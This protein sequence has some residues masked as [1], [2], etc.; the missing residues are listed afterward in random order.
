MDVTGNSCGCSFVDTSFLPQICGSG[1]LMFMG[2]VE[3]L[4]KDQCSISDP[5]RREGLD[6]I[7]TY[8]HYDFIVVG[9]GVAGPVVAS[10]LS[11]ISSWNVLLIEAGPHEPTITSVPAFAMTARG[12]VLDWNYQTENTTLACL[13][14]GGRC[15]WSR[16]KMVAG[17]SGMQ[18]MMY[19]RPHPAILDIW[20]ENVTG[21][22]FSDVLPY[23]IK[24]ENNLNPEMVE[25]GYHGFSGPMTV[26]QFPSRPEMA[27]AVV[28][29]GIELGYR[30]GDLNGQNQTGGAVA[31][32]MVFEGLRMSTS[33][34]Y[35]R[36]F[37]KE[38]DNL[39][40]LVNAQVTKVLIH[41]DTKKAYGVEYVDTNG[42]T[43]TIYAEKEVILSAGAVNSPQLLL[44]SGIGPKEDLTSVG[45][46]PIVDLPGVGQNLQN[47]VAGSVSFH[48]NDDSRN[49]L[50]L[51]AVNEFINSR[52]GNLSSTG[53][54]QTTLFMKS[55]Y[56]TDDVPD[57]Q[58]FFDGY[59][60][61]CSMTG[62]DGECTGTGLVGSCAQR[63]IYA[64]PT[65]VRPLSRGYLTLKSS[66]PLDP[67]LIYPNYLQELQ[68][69]DVLVDGL[70]L[71]LQMANT[72]AMQKYNLE[73][74][75]N[76]VSG[77]ENYT[78]ASDEYFACSV[79]MA[80]G[81]ENHQAGTC[82]MGAATDQTSVVDNELK[83]HGVSNIRVID[84]SIFPV[85]P[86]SNPTSVII[87]AA[88]KISDV[89]KAS[90]EESAPSRTV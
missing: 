26:Q 44:L 9:A 72:T 87:M 76:P 48:I 21:W 27:N 39:K 85:N 71:C 60:S 30:N 28:E 46:E 20:N 45:I 41:N 34:A 66:N 68:D 47:H 74:N 55:K 3:H 80:T 49:T 11:E 36:P 83:V 69:V 54:T 58:V 1:F 6:Y 18:G 2:L 90:W 29:A 67:P 75:V 4:L 31:Q 43:H 40:L 82:K 37:Y 32:M 57:L 50:T 89:I 51:A 73:L 56:V 88:E 25:P 53:I 14:T 7:P 62:N 16:G 38:R 42:V 12:T 17:S 52:T 23:Y 61:S 19:T 15:K 78:F 84:A 79:R 59:S 35:L 63:L 86:N 70:K 65:N 33:R 10:R 24:S 81:A 77:C 5:C 64:R 13:S 8:S 22:S